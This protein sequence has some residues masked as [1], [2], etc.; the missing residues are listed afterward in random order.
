M[1]FLFTDTFYFPID[2]YG[3]E[4]MTLC[5]NIIFVSRLEKYNTNHEVRFRSIF[6]FSEMPLNSKNYLSDK[7]KSKLIW[8]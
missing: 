4:N 6:N 3:I 7:K 8:F 1:L 2:F 5:F